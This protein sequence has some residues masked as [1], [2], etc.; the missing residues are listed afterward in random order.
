MKFKIRIAREKGWSVS[1]RGN[2]HFFPQG[3]YRVPDEMSHELAQRALHHGIGIRIDDAKDGAPEQKQSRGRP[4][5]QK[6][7]ASPSAAT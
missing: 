7:N 5:K 1:P 4:R 2:Y 3:D 6:D